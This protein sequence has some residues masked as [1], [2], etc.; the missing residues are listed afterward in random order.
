MDLVVPAA[1]D[2]GAKAGLLKADLVDSVDKAARVAQEASVVKAAK[3]AQ[4]ALAVLEA[5]V[6]QE[7]QEALEEI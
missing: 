2:K 7:A 6:A 5:K 1:Q 4:E 3:E